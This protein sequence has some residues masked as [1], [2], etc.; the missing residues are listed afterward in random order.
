MYLFFFFGFLTL[1]L[2]A[3]MAILKLRQ[4][5]RYSGKFDLID[6]IMN[7]DLER[8]EG[9][10]ETNPLSLYWN[11]PN[12][13]KNGMKQNNGL[14]YR[15][16][17][18]S[19]DSELELNNL[20]DIT[21]LGSSVTYS[22]HVIENPFEAWPAIFEEEFGKLLNRK[23]RVFN[24]GL[25]Y[26]LSSELVSHFIFRG[27]TSN[28]KILIWE[29]PGNDFLPIACNDDT[30]DYR[31]TRFSLGF[32]RRRYES[33]MLRNSKILQIFY[34]FWLQNEHLISMEPKGLDLKYNKN[35][36]EILLKNDLKFFKHNLEIL[37]NFCKLRNIKL[38]LIPFC[39]PS[40]EK[41]KFFYPENF[42]AL[43][44]VNTQ[45]NQLMAE[46]SEINK[47]FVQYIPLGDYFDDDCF[48]DSCHLAIE[49]EQ[50]K[51]KYVANYLYDWIKCDNPL[52]E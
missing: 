4:I 7:E 52:L 42:L 10:F 45:M 37:I 28:P 32:P 46:L 30:P 14:G 38:C 13:F 12:R 2:F 39:R 25:N 23:I 48:V 43:E 18:N 44:I 29:G 20:C 9:K 47:D 35:L 26:A 22:D 3:Y 21:I 19:F 34:L 16:T 31:K 49:A 27:Y 36:S 5:L 40:S 17:K 6:Y 24:G 41:L 50:L 8:P 1:E 51:A 15:V 33:F 11:Q